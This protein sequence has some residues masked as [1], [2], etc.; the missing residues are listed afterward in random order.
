[1]KRKSIFYIETTMTIVRQDG[2]RTSS[3]SAVN[4]YFEYKNVACR[5]ARWLA[6]QDAAC[7]PGCDGTE[8]WL[9]SKDVVLETGDRSYITYV[10]KEMKKFDDGV[11]ALVL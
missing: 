7:L 10:V 4:I 8:D 6:G 11:A 2:L 5:V 9:Q 1:M 3:T